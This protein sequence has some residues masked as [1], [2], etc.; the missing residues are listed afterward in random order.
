MREGQEKESERKRENGKR[1]DKDEIKR[2][3]K[4]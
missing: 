2:K 4:M 3:G 1:R